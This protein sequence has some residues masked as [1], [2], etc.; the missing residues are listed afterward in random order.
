MFGYGLLPF[1]G[2][3]E[4]GTRVPPDHQKLVFGGLSFPEDE[5]EALR[6]EG[7]LVAKHPTAPL[8]VEGVSRHPLYS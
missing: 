5:E 2:P 3:T 4:G 1:V 8:L 6:R 7:V